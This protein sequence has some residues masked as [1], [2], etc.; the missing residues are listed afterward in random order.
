M[1]RARVLVVEDEP[2]I[3]NVLKD[4]LSD[5]GH[6]RILFNEHLE[7]NGREIVA[8]ACAMGLEGIVSKERQC[9]LPLWPERDLA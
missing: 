7:G 8:K 6:P 3:V 5:A 9:T 1:G 4:L 2:D